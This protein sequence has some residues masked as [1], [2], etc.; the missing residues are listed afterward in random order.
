MTCEDQPQSPAGHGNGAVFSD[1]NSDIHGPGQEQ[2]PVGASG[3]DGD[4][5]ATNDKHMEGDSKNGNNS[6]E[7]SH[8][9]AIVPIVTSETHEDSYEKVNKNILGEDEKDP[10]KSAS[11]E[12]T[13]PMI[14]SRTLEDGDEKLNKNILGE[15]DDEKENSSRE[16]TESRNRKDGDEKVDKNSQLE[17]HD[18]KETVPM[19]EPR[20]HEG[21]GEKVNKNSQVEHH[22]AKETVPMIEPRT[23]E[24]GDE[25]VN[26]NSQVEHHDAKETVPMI[27]PRTHEDGVEKVIN[28]PEDISGRRKVVEMVFGSFLAIGRGWRTYMKH[29]VMRPGMG[30]AFLYLTVLGFDNITTGTK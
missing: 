27:E 23:H 25:K 6:V 20:T 18:V 12:E 3:T 15:D 19:I 14:E 16:R 26:K 28:T 8:G 9:E 22:D 10:K 4:T 29:P 5:G 2:E 21:G 7:M 30:L 1:R 17:H 24:D 11:R 13:V